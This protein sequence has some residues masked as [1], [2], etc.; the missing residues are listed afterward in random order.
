[1]NDLKRNTILVGDAAARLRQLPTASID[2]VITSPPYYRLR[3]YGVPQQLGLEATV[4]AWVTELRAVTCQLARVIK[5]TGSLWLNLGD[6]Y[7]RHVRYGA[8]PKSLFLAPERLL[9]ALAG[10]GWIVRNKVIWAKPNPMP[11]SVG[12]RLSTSYDVVYF[13]VRS[14]HYFFDLDQIRQPHQTSR[15]SAERRSAPAAAPAWAGPHAG[16]QDGLARTRPTGVPGHWLGKN[17]G[18]V[19]TVAAASYRGAHFATFPE[20][21]IERPLLAS[22]PE[23]ICTRCALP[24]R[25][26]VTIRRLGLK[27][28]P[29]ARDPHVRR[30]EAYWRTLR[31]LGD[32]VPCGCG[33]PTRPGVVLDPFFGTGT[34]GV[35]AERLGRDWVG[36]ELNPAY[37]RLATERLEAARRQPAPPS[38]GAV[39]AWQTARDSPVFF[40]WL[41]G[42]PSGLAGLPG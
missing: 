6:S 32:L 20:R 34:V 18:D 40:Q 31:Q 17:P 2:C 26:P 38:A 19:W 21:L 23:A 29:A 15:T 1:M 39:G 11:D 27:A 9:V 42:S 7:S 12:D 24:W 10:D 37:A 28:L 33:A 36:I 5:P 4:E 14:R 22:C 13:L 35:V 25:R 3:D 30:Y 16:R 8:P 41:F